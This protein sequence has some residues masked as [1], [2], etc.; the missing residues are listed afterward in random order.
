MY[1]PEKKYLK[2]IVSCVGA[3]FTGAWLLEIL[4][5]IN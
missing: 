2:F 3:L 5:V 1:V 4:L